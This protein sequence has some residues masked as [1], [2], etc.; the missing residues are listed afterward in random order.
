M[1]LSTITR[2]VGQRTRLLLAITLVQAVLAYVCIKWGLVTGMLLYVQQ[3]SLLVS[4]V[5]LVGVGAGWL[6]DS[7]SRLARSLGISEL[8]IGL[9]IVAFGTSAPEMAASLAA[10]FKG[11]GDITVAN[12]IGS[13][14]FNLCFIL[15]GVALLVKGGLHTERA[16]I[17][18]DGP[19]LLGA[20]LLL[21]L[22]VG[23]SP[24]AGSAQDPGLGPSW[25]RLLNLK[26][27]LGEGVL[28]TAALAVY[29]VALYLVLRRDRADARS[30]AGAGLAGVVVNHPAGSHGTGASSA[31]R[32]R[33]VGHS[34]WIDLGFFVVGLVL[35]VGGCHFLVGHAEEAGGVVQGFGALWFAKKWGIPDYVVGVTIVAAGTSVPEFV[36]SL[37]AALRGAFG[38]SA[39]NLLGSD[40]F[41][42]LGVVGLSG[43]VLQ[44]PVAPPVMV[45][46]LAVPSLMALSG[47]VLVTIFFMWT[48]SRVSRLEGL[49][50]VLIGIGRWI[51]DFTSQ[52]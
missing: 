34:R 13:N 14:I 5:Y 26:L 23:A 16:L 36:V 28:L 35:V 42:V 2:A 49:L 22:F 12:V 21:F 8:V 37:V 46:T 50:L 4:I 18:R 38:I 17:I 19:V 39:G 40:I 33:L 41:N 9:T 29:L 10:G 43:I 32:G 11:N 52:A 51:L 20:T 1:S 30:H 3:V 25:L 7:A 47:L 45:S 31:D 27:E 48:G 15:G 24:F 44:Q 6:V